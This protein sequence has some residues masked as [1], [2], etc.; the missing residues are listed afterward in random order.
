MGCVVN[1]PGES[2]HAD[3]GM[4]GGGGVGIIYRKGKQVR[5]VSEADMVNALMD[6]VKLVLSEKPS[7][8]AAESAVVAV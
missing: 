8:N 2:E 1:G 7:K 3:V 6:E 4:A 5:R